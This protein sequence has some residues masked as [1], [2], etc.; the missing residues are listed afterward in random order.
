MN[1]PPPPAHDEATAQKNI[2][3]KLQAY[4]RVDAAKG[5]QFNLRMKDIEG[6]KKAQENRCAAC[7]IE[8]LWCYAPV[9]H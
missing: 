4:K 5:L 6:L 3:S 2:G 8:M 1:S 7:N 9:L